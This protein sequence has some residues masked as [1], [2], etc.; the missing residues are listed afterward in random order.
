MSK[1]LWEASQRAKNKSNLLE[2]GCGNAC[3]TYFFA[4]LLRYGTNM[5]IIQKIC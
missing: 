2:L 5:G 3:D 4:F 1:K